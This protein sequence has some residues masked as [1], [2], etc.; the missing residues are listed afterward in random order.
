[1]ADHR[2]EE[3]V[4]Y[5]LDKLGDVPVLYDEGQGIWANRVQATMAYDPNATHHLVL[6]DDAILC[7]DFVN[8]VQQLIDKKPNHAFSLYFG[9]R[10]RTRQTALDNLDAGGWEQCWFSWGLA[11][12]LPVPI[13]ESAIAYGER[14]T[15]ISAHDDTRLARFMKSRQHPVWYPLPS[16]V[17]HRVSKSLMENSEGS[18][19]VAV[20]FLGE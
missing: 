6:Q 8:E 15:D 16:L 4:E 13:I 9:D 12:V 7:H 11:I 3:M 5:L 17:D 10:V 1:M 19:R 20:K 14:Q 18:K 2:R